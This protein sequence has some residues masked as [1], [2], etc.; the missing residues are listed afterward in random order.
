MQSSLSKENQKEVVELRRYFHA[1]PELK[2]QEVQTSKTII[3]KLKSYGYEPKTGIAKTGV[4]ALHSDN[5]KRCI[6]LRADMDGLPIQEVNDVPYRSQNANVMHACG[7][8]MHVASLLMTAKELKSQKIPGNLKFI[9][10]PAEEG[11][12]GADLMIKEGVLENPKV[13]AAFG[14]HVWSYMPLGK[15]GVTPGPI[16]ASVDEFK[17]VIK[18][19][20]GHGAAPQDTVDSVVVACQVVNALQSIVSRYTDPLKP[21][22]V[23]VGKIQGGSAFNIIA[24]ETTLIGTV[25]TMD[26]DLWQKM[27]GLFERTV[28]GVTAAYGATYELNFDRATPVTQNDPKM[29]A[30]VHEMAASIVGEQN[31]VTDCKTMGGEDFSFI[32]NKVPGCFFFVG[33]GDEKVGYVNHHSPRFD[34]K[35]ESLLIGVDIMKKVATEYFPYFP[36]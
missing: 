17:L 21:A 15:V 25:R 4:V 34:I 31:V 20:G 5:N 18:G 33:A 28:K 35:E 19:K 16:M 22:V 14:L 36:K 26:K 2:Y 7:H 9:F 1:H 23:T 30:F 10:Q 8:D 12:N 3:E 29:T 32:L 6:L 13:E 27:P 24:E 11:G